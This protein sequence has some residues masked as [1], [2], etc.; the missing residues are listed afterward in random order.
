MPRY[1]VILSPLSFIHH[2]GLY[3]LFFG[4]LPTYLNTEISVMAPSSPKSQSLRLRSLPVIDIGPWVHPAEEHYRGHNG[5]RQS[6]SA[7]LHAACLTYGF[8]YLDISSYASQ[9][10]MD[11]L[12][13]LAREFFSL[14]QEKKDELALANQDGARGEKYRDSIHASPNMY[15]LRIPEAKGKCYKRQGRQP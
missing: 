2:T 10:E 13:Q 15:Y 12:A 11:E 9:A 6:T 8:F 14:P 4:S 7:A 3:L 1:N 5:G